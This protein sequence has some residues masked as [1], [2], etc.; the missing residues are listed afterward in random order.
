MNNAT[1][2]ISHIYKN[3]YIS[4]L[5]YS[6]NV[7]RL[8]K[9]NIKAIL[10]L[11]DGNK[12]GH[13]LKLYEDNNITHK[14]L[15]IKD[16]TSY[17]LSDS[18][19]ASWEFL[20]EHVKKNY[21]IL[22]HCKQGISRS[23]TIVAHFLMRKMHEYNFH[24]KSAWDKSNER[25]T[26]EILELIHINRPCSNPNKSFIRQLEKYEELNIQKYESV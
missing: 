6:Y 23:P 9:H 3:I 14:F 26:G 11:G 10:Y 13:V 12:P 7:D 20:N 19:N 16:M 18:F 15:K 21:N 25:I 24:R 5:Y 8:N 22:V 1:Y 4:D 2:R 17:N